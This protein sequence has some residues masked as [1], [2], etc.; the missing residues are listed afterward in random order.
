MKQNCAIFS[1][2]SD[3]RDS[4]VLNRCG[5]VKS[6][7]WLCLKRCGYVKDGVVMLKKVWLISSV[8]VVHH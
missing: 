5:Y 6:H 2:E 7:V 8:F 3:S 4:V 1:R